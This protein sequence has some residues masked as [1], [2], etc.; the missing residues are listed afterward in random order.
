M[1]NPHQL[2][3]FQVADTLALDVY[4]LTKLFPP[5]ER[6][7][8][9]Q[10]LRRAAV[11]VA[12]NIV[13]GCSR[14]GRADFRRFIEI[15][16]GSAMEMRYQLSLA[17]RLGYGSSDEVAAAGDRA[18]SLVRGLIAFEKVLREPER[19]RLVQAADDGY[20]PAP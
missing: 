9:T 5:D 1:R 15:A 6:F 20:D 10:Q 13:E 18:D 4:R 17:G 7:G 14:E 3:V 12:S 8:L 19:I 2:T 11:S 16:T